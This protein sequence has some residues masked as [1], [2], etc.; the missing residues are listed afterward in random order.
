[1]TFSFM[2]SL[3]PV[4]IGSADNV[5]GLEVTGLDVTQGDLFLTEGEDAIEETLNQTD[6][7]TVVPGDIM[8]TPC[9]GYSVEYRVVSMERRG[10]GYGSWVLR[11]GDWN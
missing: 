7:L 1:M 4:T 8:K 10:T 2:Y 6:D 9:P 3:V 11:D 5:T